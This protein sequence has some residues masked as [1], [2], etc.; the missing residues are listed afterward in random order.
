L[1]KGGSLF[2]AGGP[3][4]LFPQIPLLYPKNLLQSFR[5]FPRNLPFHRLKNFR[6]PGLKASSFLLAVWSSSYR[7][8]GL[9]GLSFRH[10][11]WNSSCQHPGLNGSPYQNYEK[12]GLLCLTLGMNA[13]LFPHKLMPWLVLKVV[14]QAS[15]HLS[16]GASQD[17]Q[18]QQDCPAFYPWMCGQTLVESSAAP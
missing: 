14:L 2:F 11:V 10:A 4:N 9:K 15:L 18:Q 12:T 5:P 6:H 7:R 13:A 8:D 1:T 17:V 3:P 16:S